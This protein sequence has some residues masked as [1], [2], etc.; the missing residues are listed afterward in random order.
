MVRMKHNISNILAELVSL[1][2]IT[3][4]IG[5]AELRTVRVVDPSG[6]PIAGAKVVAVSLSINSS[7]HVT[8]K[9]GETSLPDN[10]QEVKWMQ[11]SMPGFQTLHTEKPSSWPSS[12]TL[13]PEK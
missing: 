10:I 5:C 12:V 9:N 8:D 13:H 7:P 1:I 2:A 4:L 11:V 3:A 6:Q